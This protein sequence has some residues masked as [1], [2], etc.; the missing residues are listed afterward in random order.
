MS[1]RQKLL[2]RFLA[3]PKDFTYDE[4]ATLLKRYGYLKM[5]AGKT[6]GSQAAFIDENSKHIIRLHKPHPSTVLKRYQIDDIEREL[7]R[8]GFLP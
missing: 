1:R 2:T 3:K 7:K 6:S 5:K 8:K 4:L